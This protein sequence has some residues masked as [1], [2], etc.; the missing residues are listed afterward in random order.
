VA[1][2]INGDGRQPFDDF[3]RAS[4]ERLARTAY[5]LTWDL[6]ES[7]DVVQEALLRTAKQWSRVAAMEFPYAYVRRIVVNLALRETRRR[8]G[9]R[10]PTTPVDELDAVSDGRFE[11]DLERIDAR[12]EILDML[13]SLPRRQRAVLVLRY[14][15]DLSEDEIAAQ[16]DWPVGTVKSASSRALA[17]LRRHYAATNDAALPRALPS[18]ITPTP[19]GIHP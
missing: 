18:E 19:K 12:E 9:D 3:V 8:R 13:A 6:T 11:R 15:E 5:L 4:S 17:D 7:E 10:R 2:L 1:G 14:F 16:L